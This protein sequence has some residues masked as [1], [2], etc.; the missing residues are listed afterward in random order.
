M[1]LKC[2]NVNQAIVLMFLLFTRIYDALNALNA[3]RV[4]LSHFF[5]LLFLLL[6]SRH[7]TFTQPFPKAS[8]PLTC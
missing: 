6:L 3:L 2:Q 5:F 7:I 4:Y 8:I 1:Y